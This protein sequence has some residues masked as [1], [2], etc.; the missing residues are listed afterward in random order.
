MKLNLHRAAVAGVPET[1]PLHNMNSTHSREADAT[2]RFLN[3]LFGLTSL[4]NV[5]VRLWDGTLWPD[6]QPRAVTLMLKHPGALRAMFGSG[7]EKALAEAYLHDDFDILGE[8]ESAFEIADALAEGR[9]WKRS[10]AL[11][12]LLRSLP[13]DRRDNGARRDLFGRNSRRHS[14]ARDRQ[15]I[16]FHYDVSNDFYRLWLDAKMVYSC[17]YFEKSDDPLDV[18]Q[19]A[20]LDYLCRKLRLKPGQRVLDIGCGWGGLA[21]HAAWHYGA[22]VTGVTLSEKQA[23][24]AKARA[25]DAGLSDRVKIELRDY[26]ALDECEPFDAIVSVGMS[27]HVGSENL[28]AY[29]AA[30]HALLKA[31][32]I[33]LN[34]AIGEGCRY[35]PSHGPSFIDEYVFPDSDIPPLR[36]VIDAA[37]SA[38]FEVRD[39]ENLREHYA[40]TLRH[41]VRRLEAHHEQALAF[42]NEPTYRVWRL[43]MAGSADGFAHGRLAIYQTLLAKPDDAGRAHLPLTRGDWYAPSLT[44]CNQAYDHRSPHHPA[45]RRPDRILHRP[46]KGR[47]RA[48]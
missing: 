3:K 2:L 11:A 39:V 45:G 26:R 16:A 43:Y 14:H 30:A 32:G 15:A 22:N 21:L 7:T 23:E 8:M 25:A 40:L 41:W 10:L 9:G 29:F 48:Y 46:E 36:R 6:E 27:E 1:P 24:F 5:A 12:F 33:F 17:A 42:V 20:K 31:G 38:G 35:R 34:H 28:P 18:A 19:T 44:Q 37:E 13:K 4:R 47:A